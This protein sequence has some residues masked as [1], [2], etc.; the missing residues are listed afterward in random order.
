V[1]CNISRVSLIDLKCSFCFMKFEVL[2]DIYCVFSCRYED[3]GEGTPK[4]S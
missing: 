2:A 1:S 4:S 3:I